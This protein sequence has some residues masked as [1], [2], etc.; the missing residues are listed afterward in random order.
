MTNDPTR[1][2]I[3]IRPARPA[4]QRCDDLIGVSQAF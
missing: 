2:Q 3:S 4:G 1:N